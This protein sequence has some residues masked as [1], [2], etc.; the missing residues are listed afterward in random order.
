MHFY[1]GFYHYFYYLCVKLVIMSQTTPISISNEELAKLPVLTFNGEII[2]IDTQEQ[3]EA[4]CKDLARYPILGFDTETRPSFKAGII[5]KVALL[6]LSSPDRSYLFRLNKIPLDKPIIAL[7]ESK[8]IIKLGADVLGD[9]RALKGLRHFKEQGFVDLQKIVGDWGIADKSLKKMAAIVLSH[10]I[11]K[12]QR[13][14][15]WEAANYTDQQKIYAAT[16]AWICIQIYN[17]L[18]TMKKVI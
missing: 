15:N 12:A 14:S 10:R 5:N 18:Q 13:L 4:A 8:K 1:Y 9:L 3:I 16:D 17:K 11:S 6:Q 2:V 7:L